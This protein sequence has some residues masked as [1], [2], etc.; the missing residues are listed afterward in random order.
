MKPQRTFDV[1]IPMTPVAKGRPIVTRSGHA[2]T[3]AKTRN[4]EATIKQFVWDAVRK[5]DQSLPLFGSDP[6]EVSIVFTFQRTK[7][8]ILGAFKPTRPDLDNLIKCV[9][10]SSNGILWRDD[11]QVVFITASK[12]WGLSPS[13]TLKA[14]SLEHE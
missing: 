7:H 14:W 3:P 8:A 13:V 10:D 9:L 11:G 12:R 2:F 6:V 4:A 1:E 5:S